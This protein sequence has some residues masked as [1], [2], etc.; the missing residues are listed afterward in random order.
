MLC[1]SRQGQKKNFRLLLLHKNGQSIDWLFHRKEQP[2]NR[3][4]R[5][6]ECQGQVYYRTI[7]PN[8]RNLIKTPQQSSQYF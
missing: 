4:V 3:N 5:V 7:H 1:L 2:N 8:Y 6:T